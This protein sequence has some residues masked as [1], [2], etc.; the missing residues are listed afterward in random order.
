MTQTL[1]L[2]ADVPMDYFDSRVYPLYENDIYAWFE[3]FM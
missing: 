2:V 1:N 3:H